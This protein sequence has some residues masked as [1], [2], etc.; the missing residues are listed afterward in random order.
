MAYTVSTGGPGG[1]HGGT[2]SPLSDFGVIEGERHVAVLGESELVRLLQGGW[3]GA[4][5]TRVLG[6]METTTTTRQSKP[7]PRGEVLPFGPPAIGIGRHT[8]QS[9]AVATDRV[10]CCGV[11]VS[12]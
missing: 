9:P 8:C 12:M 1:L 6:A 3:G 4:R 7:T 5:P 11:N 10:L 2:P